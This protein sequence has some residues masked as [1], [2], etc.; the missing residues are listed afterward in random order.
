[1]AAP[2]RGKYGGGAEAHARFKQY[3]YRAVSETNLLDVVRVGLQQ[4]LTCNLQCCGSWESIRLG[5]ACCQSV[6]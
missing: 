5:Y 1:M 6:A 3:D 2:D 4:Y